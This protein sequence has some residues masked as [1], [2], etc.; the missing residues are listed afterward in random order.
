[1]CL[2]DVGG[3]YRPPMVDMP[4]R[5]ELSVSFSSVSAMFLVDIGGRYRP[6]VV[7][8]PGFSS[9]TI[10]SYGSI[11]WS[12]P[13]PCFA[14]AHR[15]NLSHL[16]IQGFQVST[17]GFELGIEII[18]RVVHLCINLLLRSVELHDTTVLTLED[19]FQELSSLITLGS[20]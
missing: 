15:G 17:Q 1:M 7:D 16:I 19:L 6:P 11:E 12:T 3:R 5:Y 18:V 4:G 13:S 8:I 9:L 10:V 2:A 20:W 14:L